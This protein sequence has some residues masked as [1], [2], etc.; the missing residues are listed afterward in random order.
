MREIIFEISDYRPEHYK[1]LYNAYDSILEVAMLTG[2]RFVDFIAPE[3][4]HPFFCHM[5]LP[6][7]SSVMYNKSDIMKLLPKL[8][9]YVEMEYIRYKDKLLFK[10]RLKFVMFIIKVILSRYCASMAVVHYIDNGKR[11]ILANPIPEGKEVAELIYEIRN[12]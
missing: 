8:R 5:I 4:G 2:I 3:N 7:D 11:Y 1:L 12:K 9:T 10:S 6:E